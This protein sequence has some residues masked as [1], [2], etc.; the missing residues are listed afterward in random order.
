MSSLN[1][2]QIIGNVT[3]DIE[4]KSTD[5]G[6]KYCKFSVATNRKWTNKESGEKTE[7]VE[8]HNVIAWGRLS[9]IL[10]EYVKKGHKIYC[11]GRMKTDSWEDK[12]SGKKM[13]RAEIV[14]ENM[15][16]LQSRGESG[17]SPAKAA[18]KEDSL[19]ELGF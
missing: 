16:M 9:E 12:D 5:S 11:E 13:Y 19:D 6:S 4:L 10:E 2:V 17:G 14:L 3:A 15:I 1:K 8:F 7:E 18:T